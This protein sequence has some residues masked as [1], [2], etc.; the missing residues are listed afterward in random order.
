MEE[1][2]EKELQ[3]TQ[4]L[5]I[6]KEQL[7]P[8]TASEIKKVKNIKDLDVIEDDTEEPDEKNLY[9]LIDMMYETRE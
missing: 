5:E 1:A 8:K 6:T 4:E 2:P 7:R 9:D 3:S